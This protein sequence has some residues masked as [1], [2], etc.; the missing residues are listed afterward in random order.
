MFLIV[1]RVLLC[2]ALVNGLRATLIAKTGA[3]LYSCNLE[4]TP[5][6]PGL[7][8][9]V[10]SLPREQAPKPTITRGRASGSGARVVVHSINTLLELNLMGCE[11]RR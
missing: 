8:A 10:A 2:W 9:G 11:V 5:A 6:P 3:S 4:L 7:T 1:R